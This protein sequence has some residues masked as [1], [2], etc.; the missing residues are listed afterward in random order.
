MKL[1]TLVVFDMA[2]TTVYDEGGIVN[3]CLREALSEA[4]VPVT[5]AQVNTVMGLPK[6]E[7]I[8]QL[9]VC[10]SAERV[11]EIHTAFVTRM[12]HFYET[13][14]RV[15]E[16][17]GTSLVFVKL[18]D[19]GIKIALD[20]GFSRD[21][22]DVIIGRLGWRGSIDGSIASDEVER[23]RPYPDLIEALCQKF[24]ITDTSTVAK[25][26]D[27]PSDLQEGTSAGC[28][29]VVGV[30]EGSHTREELAVHPHTH[31]IANITQLPALL[32]V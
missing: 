11:Q 25:L 24:G 17:D 29:W 32:G 30:C 19:A 23:G 22:V 26:G 31:L 3:W 10:P 14:P 2:G 27:T 8:R 28:G 6:P 13:S 12:V 21:I 16:I 9:L 1:P 18:R 7:A 20:T 5:E 15:R 4:G